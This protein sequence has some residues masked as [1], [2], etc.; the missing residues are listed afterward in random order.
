[1]L[2]ALSY[3]VDSLLAPGGPAES[4]GGNSRLAYFL[5]YEAGETAFRFMLPVLSGYIAKSI[6][7]RPGLLLGFVAGAL[8]G[9]GGGG[10]LGALLGGFL[11]GYVM[12]FVKWALRFLPRAM[13]GAKNVL[14]YPVN[15]PA[16]RLRAGGPRAGSAHRAGERRARQMARFAGRA[17]HGGARRHSGRHDEL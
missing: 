16:H 2:I 4:L 13:E 9:T 15:R 8:A 1:M 6:A 17:R 12:V 3:L 10:F 11:A 5:K 7:D 14:F